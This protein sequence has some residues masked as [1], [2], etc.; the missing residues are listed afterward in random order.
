MRLAALLRVS[1]GDQDLASQRE[2]IVRFAE[3]EGAKDI[4]WYEEAAVSGAAK[5]RPV[6]ENLQHDARL[7]RF[8]VLVVTALDRLSRDV[9]TLLLTVDNLTRSGVALVSLREGYDFRGPM[10]R[11]MAA[12]FGALAEMERAVI[13]SRVKL[14]IEA[15]K[16]RG[17][18]F[19]KVPLVPT[20][21]EVAEILRRADAG[22]TY[23]AIAANTALFDAKGRAVRPGAD[24][25]RK[26]V[27]RTRAK[28]LEAASA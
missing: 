1:T 18:R 14:G 2:A 5:D 6:L 26:L 10:G 20:A 17:V 11:A 9:I 15:A 8:D 24:Y 19:G 16:S 21:A 28:A 23:V 7:G 27:N 12:L 3:R 25:I 4:L 13:R 22:E